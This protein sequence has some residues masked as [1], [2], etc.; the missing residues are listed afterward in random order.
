MKTQILFFL[1]LITTSNIYG[2]KVSKKETINYIITKVDEIG[3]WHQKIKIHEDGNI[4]ISHISNGII[5]TSKFHISN[6]NFKSWNKGEVHGISLECNI[7]Y[8]VDHTEI[9]ENNGLV[10]K[11]MKVSSTFLAIDLEKEIERLIK[12][13]NNL[14]SYYPPKKDLFD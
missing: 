3:N 1:I 10:Q 11:E 9:F 8:C 5:I 4:S 12:S 14:K 6:I 7:G 2:Q 13:F